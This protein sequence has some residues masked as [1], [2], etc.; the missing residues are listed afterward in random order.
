VVVALK[1]NLHASGITVLQEAAI[2]G[3]AIVCTDTGGL[4]AYFSDKEIYYIPGS[5][6]FELRN[7]I[8]KLAGDNRGSCWHGRLFPSRQPRLEQNSCSSNRHFALV[9]R[10]VAYPGLKPVSAFADPT[11]LF[12]AD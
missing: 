5:N 2:R 6:S 12:E 11:A 10:C 1:P 8:R 7:A 4:R 9:L 3:V